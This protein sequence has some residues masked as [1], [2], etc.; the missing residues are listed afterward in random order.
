M[1][2]EKF[3]MLVC[4]CV[5][6]CARCTQQGLYLAGLEYCVLFR[7]NY[8]CNHS[9]AD[10]D[11]LSMEHLASVILSPVVALVVAVI[12]AVSPFALYLCKF[13]LFKTK[14]F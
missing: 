14:V 7:R 2:P 4:V 11:Q 5:C 9:Y 13:Y 12:A 3:T 8:K 1:L 6:V 10:I